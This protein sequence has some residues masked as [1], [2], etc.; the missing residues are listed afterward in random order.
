[1]R[2]DY[3]GAEAVIQYGNTLDK[4]SGEFE[5]YGIFGVGNKDTTIT[6]VLNTIIAIPSP[7]VIAVSRSR[8]RS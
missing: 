8:R 6:V 3:N 7:T 5:S 1:M 4:D 2:H